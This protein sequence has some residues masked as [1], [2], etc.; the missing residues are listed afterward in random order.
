[1]KRYFLFFLVFCFCFTSCIIRSPKFASLDQAFAVKPGMTL[2]QVNTTLGI[3]PY[4]LRSK[5][6]SQTVY[7]YKYR[8]MERRTVPL[9]R[10]K[11]NGMKATGPL[12]DLNVTYNSKSIVTALK[13]KP[14]PKEEKSQYTIDVNSVFTLLTVTAPAVLVYLGLQHN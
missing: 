10:K 5:T 8:T 4:A 6:D 12:M 11:T 3:P 14:S 7:V 1:M 9:F 2:E 13:S